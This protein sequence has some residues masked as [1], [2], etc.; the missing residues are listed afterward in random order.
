METGGEEFAIGVVISAKT[1]LGEEFEGQIVA[2]DRPSNLLVIQEGVGRAESGERRNV[3]VLKANYIR[4]FSVV[5]KGDDPLD[6]PGCMLDLDAIYA[7]EEAALRQAEIEAERIG[8][9]V[10]PEAQSIFDALSKT[11]PVQWDKT[12]IIV[13]K[14]VRVRSPY[15]P[16][17][18]SGGT[19]AAN[20]RVK[21]V[22]DFERKRL[23]ARVPGQFS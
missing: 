22:I 20:E 8:V 6:P 14:E 13:M 19:A 9:G 1:T 2:F 10:T 7:R 16:E 15:L 23:H 17:N 4:E 5:S 21:K 18:V 11:L 12:D 3:R